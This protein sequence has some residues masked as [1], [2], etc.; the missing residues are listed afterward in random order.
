MKMKKLFS[1]PADYPG[2]DTLRSRRRTFSLVCL[3]C[4]VF[5]FAITLSGGTAL[6]HE[7]DP[8]PHA[9][10]S[11]TIPST[12]PPDDVCQPGGP[13]DTDHK[14]PEH[15]SLGNIGAKLA[16][17]VSDLWALNMSFNMPQFY[18]GDANTGDPQL[19]ATMLLQPILPIPLH[20]TGDA[21]WRLVTRPVIPLIFSEPIPT[22][23][24]EFDHKGGIGD[25]QLPLLVNLPERYSGNFLLGA[26]A[27]G[28]FPSA[29]D[30][31]LGQDQWAL[32]PAAVFGYKTKSLTAGVFPNYFWKVGSSGQD[33]DTPDISQGSMLYFLIF[34]LPNAWQ[35]GMNPTITY[36]D[37]AKPDNRW[38]VPVGLFAAKTIKF[39]KLPVNIKA[40]LEYSVVSPD[41][42]G[43]RAQFRFQI[44][45]VI[46]SLIKN[47][48]FGK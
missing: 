14:R 19:G 13:C 42:F 9:E 21:A 12:V 10:G 25:I 11:K 43:Q 20:G 7:A 30:D 1:Y 48:I 4:G 32:G 45:P 15:G 33:D 44:T 8:H 36:N 16:N 38:N 23:F 34:N 24:N 28:L 3:V 18:D 39:G 47:P 41:A 29:T 40:G 2:K 6:A 5:L 26:G 37:K 31:D 27:V 35:I 46:Q 17:P 22:G